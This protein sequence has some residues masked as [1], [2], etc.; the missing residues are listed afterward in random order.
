MLIVD[1]IIVDKHKS[2]IIK[3]LNFNFLQKFKQIFRLKSSSSLAQFFSEFERKRVRKRITRKF[4]RIFDQTEY[5]HLIK[6]QVKRKRVRNIYHPYH[7][8]KF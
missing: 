2:S 3:L 8:W 1:S 7:K 5:L 6:R 4:H